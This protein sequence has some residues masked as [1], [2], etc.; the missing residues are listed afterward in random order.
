MKRSAIVLA[1]V[2][3]FGLAGYALVQ[4]GRV[5]GD[6]LARLVEILR[7]EEGDVIAD[8]GAG[9][10]R[11]ALAL[12]PAVGDTGRVYATEVDPNDLERIR[13]RVERDDASNVSVVEGSQ[14]DTGLPDA[15]CDAILLRR[16]YH[17]FHNPRVMQD[18]LRNA[19]R[20]DGRLL[21][22][23]FD[24]RRRWSRPEGVPES[25]GGHG[26][27]KEMLVTEMERAGFALVD[28]AK[29]ANGDYALVF[30]VGVID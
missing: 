4:G 10:G 17:H 15:C 28:E 11:W 6:E 8:V 27:S 20:G 26:I 13:S 7:I 23:D 9:D 14:D 3:G 18:E 2:F 24:T 5:D 29:W 19:L 12:A 30:E 16:V 25:R 1:S 21:I 22:I